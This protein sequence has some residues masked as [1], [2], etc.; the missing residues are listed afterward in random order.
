MRSKLICLSDAY[1]D[2]PDDVAAITMAWDQLPR[3]CHHHAYELT[4]TADEARHLIEAPRPLTM[5]GRT[6]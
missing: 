1:G 6:G 5:S 3:G 4:P 2:R